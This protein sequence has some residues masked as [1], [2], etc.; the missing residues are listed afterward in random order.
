VSG[1]GG[2]EARVLASGGV[3]AGRVA[4]TPVGV[5]QR[6]AHGSPTLDGSAMGDVA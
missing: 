4:A 6:A 3:A 2:P 1:T 5:L